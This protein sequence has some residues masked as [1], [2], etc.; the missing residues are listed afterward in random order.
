MI[1]IENISKTEPYL[2]FLEFYK[3]AISNKQK[4]VQASAISTFDNKSLEVN[5][6]F[7]NIKYIMD[8]DWIFFSNYSSTKANEI[9]QLRNIHALFYWDTID[10]QIR[11]KAKIK[12]TDNFLSDQHFYKRSKEKNAL[13][14]CSEQSQPLK[15]FEDLK[16]I[17]NKQLNNTNNYNRPKYWGGYSFQPY[18]IEF[19]EGNE[20]RLNKRRQYKKNDNSWCKTFLQP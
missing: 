13:A 9:S 7:V 5:A 12:K 20:Y 8:E 14:I 19:W 15:S 3:K 4:N 1:D 10:V 18:L 6:R 11:M 16:E 2:I 17:Y